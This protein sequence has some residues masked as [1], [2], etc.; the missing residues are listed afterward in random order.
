VN[1]TDIN[2]KLA[3]GVNDY[4]TGKS[5]DDPNFVKFSVKMIET[6]NNER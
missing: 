3:F 6:L 2:F 5:L 1:L 4:N